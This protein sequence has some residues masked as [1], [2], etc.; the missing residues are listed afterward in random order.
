MSS[1][2]KDARTALISAGNVG[3]SQKTDVYF[4]M[5]FP[6]EIRLKGGV[7]FLEMHFYDE[8]W[9]THTMICMDVEQAKQL[10]A[11]ITKLIQSGGE[12]TGNAEGE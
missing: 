10:V 6:F 2:N 4:S 8:E 7:Y 1:E 11:R 12:E 9:N 5:Y 3:T